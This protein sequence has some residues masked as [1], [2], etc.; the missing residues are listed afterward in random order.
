MSD[1]FEP[2]TTGETSPVEGQ[3]VD[4]A[5]EQEVQNQENQEEGQELQNEVDQES[6]E[7]S[8]DGQEELIAGKFKST[9]DLVKAYKNLEREFHKSRQK[10]PEQNQQPQQSQD[11]N[12]AFWQVF[13]NDPMG[14][15]QFLVNQM[16]QQQTAPIYEQQANAQLTNNMNTLAQDYQQLYTEEGVNTFSSTVHSIAEELGH[17]EWIQNPPKRILQMAAQEAFGDSKADLYRKAKQQG[18]EEAENLRKQKQGLSASTSK[19][20]Q[21]QKSMEEQ[22]A[23]AIVQA[24]Y[25]GSMFG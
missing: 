20:Q 19:P 21:Q 14:T 5:A 11:N 18:K 15:V 6:E 9:D 22:I 25:G 8:P 13:Q 12:E 4:A 24:G 3:E 23:E 7:T 17:P 16:V 1:F 10:Q 2:A